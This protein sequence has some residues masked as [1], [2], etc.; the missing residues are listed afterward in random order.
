M[1]FFLQPDWGDGPFEEAGAGR[2]RRRAHYSEI[3]HKLEIEGGSVVGVLY[4]IPAYAVFAANFNEVLQPIRGLLFGP[5]T[6]RGRARIVEEFERSRPFFMEA[7]RNG[8][9]NDFNRGGFLT[10]EDPEGSG[11]KVLFG[12]RLDEPHRSQLCTGEDQTIFWQIVDLSFRILHEATQPIDLAAF[13]DQGPDW[14]SALHTVGSTAKWLIENADNVRT[15][16]KIF[17]F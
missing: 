11:R 7:I 2:A 1:R 14:E 4:W 17:G 16:L 10:Y 15:V 12:I 5:M 3:E 9:F 13:A 6:D 8:L